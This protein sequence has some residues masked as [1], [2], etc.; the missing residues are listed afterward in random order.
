MAADQRTNDGRRGFVRVASLGIAG[1]A[2]GSGSGAKRSTVDTMSEDRKRYERGLE[3]LRKVGGR[4]YEE[5]IKAVAEVSPVFARFVVEHAYGDVLARPELDLVI[6]EAVTVASLMVQGN[7]LLPIRYHLNGFLEVGGTP[8]ALVELCFLAIGIAGFPVAINTT[9][10]I[11]EVLAERG[12]T[13]RPLPPTTD[14]DGTERYLRGLRNLL[15]HSES[16]L[17]EVREIAETSPAFSRLL[18]EFV[19]GELATRD[20]LDPRTKYLSAISMLAT[21]GNSRQWLRNYVLAALRRGVPRKDILEATIQLTVYAGFPAA[22]VGFFEVVEL[23][24]DLDAGKLSLAIGDEEVDG[25]PSE[26]REARFARGA[27]TLSTTS[28]DAGERVVRSFED[29]APDLGTMIVEHSYGDIFS[30]PG[31]D[32]KVR[33]LTAIAGMASVGAKTAETPIAV[34]VHAALTA[35]ASRDEIIET[36][37]NLIPY[38]GYPKVQRALALATHVFDERE[39]EQG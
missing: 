39:Q 14:G 10:L 4:D 16:G 5:P 25:K 2:A 21:Q 19:Y 37:L 24:D 32:S 20:G 33:E 1:C 28:A 27:R 11:R 34:H 38:V 9:G 8:E 35:G 7:Y 3:V 6:R 15:I 26:R 23:F 17:R 29:I 22:I 36:L 18:V 30:R 12:S 31:L 13:I